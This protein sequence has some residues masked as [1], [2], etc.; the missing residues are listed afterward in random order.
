[1]SLKDGTPRARPDIVLE[2]LSCL[3]R[4]E[5]AGCQ[6]RF[7]WVPS[8]S[9]IT[10]G[11]ERADTL[12]EA[13]LLRENIDLSIPLG[14]CECYSVCRDKL[15]H[16]WQTEWAEYRK[17]RH[18]LLIPI[19]KRWKLNSGRRDDLVLTRLRLGHCGLAIGLKLMAK[20]PDGLCQCVETVQH[21]ILSCNRYA[22]ERRQMFVQLSDL[23]LSSFS[24]QT[25]LGY[26]QNRTC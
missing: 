1:M 22:K 2:C 4:I 26:E 11:N 25:I 21:A 13:S 19:T 9:G 18:S 12:A 17:G 20:H 3:F 16:Q 10:E 8:H 7:V 14:R 24:M 5:R 6:V 23:G 15:E